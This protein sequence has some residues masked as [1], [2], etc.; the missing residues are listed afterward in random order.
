MRQFWHEQRRIRRLPEQAVEAEG[1][2]A[3]VTV[4][5]GVS[6]QAT[7]AVVLAQDTYEMIRIVEDHSSD[8]APEKEEKEATVYE[9]YSLR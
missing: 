3:I 8:F 4:F 7:I 9:L 2:P 1:R 6:S 5:E